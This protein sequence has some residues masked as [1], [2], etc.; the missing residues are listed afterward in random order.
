MSK[1]SVPTNADLVHKAAQVADALNECV[2]LPTI[3]GFSAFRSGTIALHPE[4][5][6]D[7]ICV[8]KWAIAFGVPAVI[9]LSSSGFLRIVFPLG[10]FEAKMEVFI[11]QRRAYELGAALDIPL[12]PGGQVEVLAEALLAVLEPAVAR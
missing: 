2:H 1:H 3:R 9:D 11:S 7:E 8:A 5:F 6:A 4:L 10:Q 12:S